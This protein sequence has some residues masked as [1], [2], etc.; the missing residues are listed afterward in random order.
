MA[1]A[2]NSPLDF[3]PALGSLR[4]VL[5]TMARAQADP[6]LVD[7]LDLLLAALPRRTIS[8]RAFGRDHR[9][10][11]PCMDLRAP[12]FSLLLSCLP[13]PLAEALKALSSSLSA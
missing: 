4:T 10:P 1:Q 11:G 6:A 8:A 2:K 3:G 7:P 12:G 5:T 13:L 9:R